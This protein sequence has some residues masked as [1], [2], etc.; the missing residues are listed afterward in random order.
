MPLGFS[1]TVRSIWH[2]GGVLEIG[3]E[4]LYVSSV[5]EKAKPYSVSE[6][7]LEQRI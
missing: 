3:T 2:T 7:L 4:C 5:I 1:S 6:C